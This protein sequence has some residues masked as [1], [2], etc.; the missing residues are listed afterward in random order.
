VKVLLL[1]AGEEGLNRD[2]LSMPATAADHYHTSLDWS[3]KTE[4]QKF[5]CLSFENKVVLFSNNFQTGCSI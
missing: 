4:P 3:Y 2:V 1:E 5:G